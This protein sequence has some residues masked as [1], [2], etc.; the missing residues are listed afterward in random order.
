MISQE[1]KNKIL[2][3]LYGDLPE[4]E[5][6]ALR[7]AMETDP[8]LA[9]EYQAS[10][11]IVH[12][13]QGLQI[14]KA[15]VDS[16]LRFKHWLDAQ[17]REVDMATRQSDARR[18][19]MWKYGIAA[20]ILLVL[21]IFIGQKLVKESLS[22][23]VEAKSKES[24]FQ[25]VANESTTSRIEGINR[26][27]DLKNLDPEVRDVLLNVLVNDES[28][29]V[30]LAALDALS[31]YTQDPV[32]KST[33]IKLLKDDSQPIVQISIINALVK[34]KERDVKESLQD[35]ISQEGLT[36]DVRDEAILSI[37]RL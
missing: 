22:L 2:D 4:Q 28:T 3:L 17:T 19:N 30:R 5:A 21:G 1:I 36:D 18:I 12:S 35:L 34:F 29:N 8:V 37:T 32:I 16:S 14:H 25:L 27:L 31:V 9:R 11:N 6:Q 15:G 26:S 23:A 24:L 20:S 10:K 33:L 7:E 13:L